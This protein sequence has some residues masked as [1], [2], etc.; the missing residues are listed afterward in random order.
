MIRWHRFS[1]LLISLVAVG[2]VG[3][4]MDEYAG[5]DEPLNVLGKPT[6]YAP[7]IDGR[8]APCQQI[9]GRH[10]GI[11][12][13]FDGVV[14]CV[15]GKWSACQPTPDSSQPQDPASDAPQEVP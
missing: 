14:T 11:T 15:E 12:S 1:L 13:C 2:C 7:C 5:V 9:I 10:A 6:R 8:T 3:E 4:A